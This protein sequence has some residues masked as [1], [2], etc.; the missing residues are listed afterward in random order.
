MWFIYHE[1]SEHLHG[2]EDVKRVTLNS[3]LVVKYQTFFE[4]YVL[5]VSNSK[6]APY[7]MENRQAQ[8]LRRVATFSPLECSI[9]T[10]E[11][12]SIYD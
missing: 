5:N 9:V 12:A 7:V 4:N 11:S 8:L 3:L 1:N 2:S 10:P 6:E